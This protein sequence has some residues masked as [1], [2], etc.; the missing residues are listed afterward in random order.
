M[1]N[2][3][4][5]LAIADLY[6]ENGSFHDFNLDVHRGFDPEQLKE[7]FL[8]Q[9]FVETSISHCFVIRKEVTSGEIKE[10]PVFLIT[11][12]RNV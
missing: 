2:P 6:E 5:I 7:Q 11:A 8:K 1:L 3:G 9:G 4:G 10:Y 12:V